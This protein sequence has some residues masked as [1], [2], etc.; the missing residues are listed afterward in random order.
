MNT[1]SLLDQLPSLSRLVAREVMTMTQLRFVS[2]IF[3]LSGFSIL[4]CASSSSN[5]ERDSG[6]GAHEM[7]NGG[8]GTG[9]NTNDGGTSTT[10]T[11]VTPTG[12]STSSVSKPY[13]EP[14]ETISL[15]ELPTDVPRISLEVSASE[16][17]KLE[18]DPYDSPKVIGSFKDGANVSYNP[19]DVSYRGAY[20]L[21]SLI[22][23]GNGQR[24][25]KV[26]FAKD[27]KYRSRR[28]WNFSFQQHIREKLTYDLM[29]FAGVKV[30][31][32]RHVKLTVNG[33]VSGVYLEY[34]DPDNKDW[35]MDKFGDDSGDLFKAGYDIPDMPKYFATLEY[36]GENDSE[37]DLHYRKMT[38]NDDPTKAADFSSL[39]A[40]LL[41]LNESDDE[42]IEG[43]L[44]KNFDTD[45]FLSYLVVFNF[46]SHWDSYP[47][48]PKNFWL[49]Q[50]PAL[51]RWVFIPWDMDATF[52][53]DKGYLDPM[54]TDVSV[55]YQFDEF[56]DYKGRHPEEGTAR[57]L[58]LRM[59]RVPSYR[60][61]YVARYREALQS[62]LKEDYLVS[63][64]NAL[65]GLIENEINDADREDFD[66]NVADVK[67]FIQERVKNVTSE[68]ATIP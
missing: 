2:C 15:N 17:E 63:R 48:R 54:G 22:L 65:T 35:L 5:G 36:L 60:A 55:F 6:G 57:P 8:T 58:I 61:A 50:V 20:A 24:N 41:G 27:K 44:R 32:A 33:V 39:R 52:Q 16:L 19:V 21:Q 43:F 47:Q 53:P 18:A 56:V 9:S 45:R 11:K 62:Y 51:G 64:V 3:V 66:S 38:N 12:G 29:R 67:R 30:P 10:S 7:S 4:G 34:E 37:Y 1:V 42:S 59:M 25:W 68:L 40:F 31:S 28:E 46:V 13:V 14:I 23:Y 49:Y 26:K